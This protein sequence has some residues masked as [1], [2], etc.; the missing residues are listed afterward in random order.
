MDSRNIIERFCD[1]V[2]QKKSAKRW[3]ITFKATVEKLCVAD[4]QASSAS[5]AKKMVEEQVR[6]GSAVCHSEELKG[7]EYLQIADLSRANPKADGAAAATPE[8]PPAEPSKDA[9]YPPV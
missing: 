3:Y 6:S 8:A 2:A 4:I 5:E 9:F 7:I 1:R